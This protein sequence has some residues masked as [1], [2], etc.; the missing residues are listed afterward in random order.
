[1]DG[2]M[3]VAQH[4]NAEVEI[5]QVCPQ[6]TEMIVDDENVEHSVKVEK[7]KTIRKSIVA[8]DC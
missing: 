8:R 1:V 6:V 5:C 4:T 3:K 7:E 2:A